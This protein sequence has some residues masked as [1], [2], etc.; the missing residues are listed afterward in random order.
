M[1]SIPDGVVVIEEGIN[2]ADYVIGTYLIQGEMDEDMLARTVSMA[3]EQTVGRGVF[4]LPEFNNLVEDRVAKV[5]SVIPV[6]DFESR[7]SERNEVW[8]RCIVRIAFPV[9]NTAYQ[10]PMLMTM[11][12]SDISMGG[13][14]KLVDIVLPSKFVDNFK[15]PK[16][17]LQGIREMTNTTDS[18]RPLV[19]TVLKPCVGLSAKEAGELF[20]LHAVGGADFIKDDEL[21]SYSGDLKIEERVKAVVEAEKRAF[22]ITG[23]HAIYL[24]N[25]TDSP[26]NILVNAKRAIEAGAPGVMLTPFSTGVA[27]IQILSEDPDINVPIF[28]HPGGLGAM[29]WSPDYGISEHIYLGKLFRLAGADIC[30][31]PV[32]YGRFPHKREKF[33][34]L[35]KIN[36]SPM[37]NIKTI[38]TQTGGGIDPINAYSAMQ[39]IGNDVMLVAGGSIQQHPSGVS[40]G[41]RALRQSVQAY[42]DNIPLVEAAKNNG[43]LG[44]AWAKWGPKNL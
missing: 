28:A 1:A 11:L 40:A 24:C 34:K 44:M 18:K 30:S 41:V 42:I 10:I 27:T 16:F 13:M 2:P 17:G 25:V 14:I 29:S 35:F 19:C 26:K 5:L 33:I 32:P 23:E 21:M 6:P 20:F 36:G 22:E 37:R 31:V 8:Q 39:D 43:E 7:E 15:G 4:S 38:F 9:E 12:M 3:V